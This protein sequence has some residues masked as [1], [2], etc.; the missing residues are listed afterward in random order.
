MLF[1][2]ESFQIQF[3]RYFRLRIATLENLDIWLS[4]S[5]RTDEFRIAIT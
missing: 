3:K 4:M 1:V 2:N 5:S